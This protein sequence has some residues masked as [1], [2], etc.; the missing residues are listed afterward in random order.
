MFEIITALQQPTL[1]YSIDHN[2]THTNIWYSIIYVMYIHGV[3]KNV[4]LYIILE[5]CDMSKKKIMVSNYS[6]YY[7]KKR[8][9]KKD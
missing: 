3:C 1:R 6:G 8:K 9:R 5:I 7:L 2:H 4:N